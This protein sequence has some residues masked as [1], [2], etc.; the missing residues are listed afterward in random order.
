MPSIPSSVVTLTITQ[1][2]PPMP[3]GGTVTQV[4]M[5]LRI[6]LSPGRKTANLLQTDG[7]R[8]RFQ[9]LANQFQQLV[10]LLARNTVRKARQV[11]DRRR[12]RQQRALE[13]Q[14]AAIGALAGLTLLENVVVD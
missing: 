8:N 6:M 9:L 3:L 12:L 2:A 11:L 4:L 14:A 10:H 13:G 7:L 5:S 1:K